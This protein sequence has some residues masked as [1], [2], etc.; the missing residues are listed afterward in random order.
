MREMSGFS[1]RRWTSG[2]TA[3][4]AIESREGVPTSQ[5][6]ELIATAAASGLA[7]HAAVVAVSLHRLSD[8]GHDMLRARG[9]AH[10]LVP[11][12]EVSPG[13]HEPDGWTH[14]LS[15]L[16]THCERAIAVLPHTLLGS[17]VGARVAFRLG[18]PV[19]M[20]CESVAFSGHDLTVSRAC[21][22][23]RLKEQ[24][25][26]NSPRTVVTIAGK[27]S[28]PAESGDVR[29]CD[30]HWMVEEVELGLANANSMIEFTRR[31]VESQSVGP[32]LETANIVVGG[33]RG[34]E[35][36]LGFADLA[37][38]A[39]KLGGA[40]G[41]SRVA[42]DLGWCPKS[43]QI[44]LSGRSIRADWYIAFGISGASHHMAGCARTSNLV[45]VNSD[46][47]AEIFRH[48]NYGVVADARSVLREL[49]RLV[50]EVERAEQ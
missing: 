49:I 43:W 5:S 6:L 24:L 22:G 41:A 46:R 31:E 42:C 44:G 8:A 29:E 2:A 21:F 17:E 20:N 50:E 28:F 47:S 15:G 45:A 39:E 35:G 9:C 12:Q 3:L 18:C 23:A 11:D 48:A 32:S 40:P 25:H 19:V 34:L 38:L 30:D 14:F 16:L 36:P 13:M 33:G 7:G 27:A 37:T 1:E 26:V 10:L 4:V